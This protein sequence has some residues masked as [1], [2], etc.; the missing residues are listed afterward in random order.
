MMEVLGGRLC[1]M[2]EIAPGGRFLHQIGMS[3]A[4]QITDAVKEMHASGVVHGDLHQA[5]IVFDVL[6]I[7]EWRSTEDVCSHLGKPFVEDVPEELQGP[8]FPKY[9]VLC[10]DERRWWEL[11]IRWSMVPTIKIIDFSEAS[12]AKPGEA[13]DKELHTAINTAAPEAV[14]GDLVTPAV[15][16]W[17]VGCIIF[18]SMADHPL[19]CA[20]WSND[21]IIVQWV[22]ALGRFPDRWWNA[23]SSSNQYFNE[24]G[25][26]LA[27]QEKLKQPDSAIE[28][29]V[30]NLT[31]QIE[32]EP[33]QW[34]GNEQEMAE[35]KRLMLAIFKLEPAERITAEEAADLLPEVWALGREVY[36]EHGVKPIEYK[37]IL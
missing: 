5:N 35:Y 32:N 16:V 20:M 13:I 4:L 15:D 33:A 30:V 8:G 9:F 27:E 28:E 22:L 34:V 12:F 37:G 24:E 11:C 7:A 2:L 26:L 21:E 6:N 25:D 19:W 17:A 29:R 1:D 3:V 31:C 36:R 10:V 14:F 18:G 23:W